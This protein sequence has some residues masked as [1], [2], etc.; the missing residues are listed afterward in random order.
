MNPRLSVAVAVRTAT[1]AFN[2]SPENGEEPLSFLVPPKDTLIFE[3]LAL[4]FAVP[5]AVKLTVLTP[6]TRR[7]EE[8]VRATACVFA[9]AAVR[10][11]AGEETSLSTAA[12]K[13]QSLYPIFVAPLY[14]WHLIVMYV[15]CA[16]LQ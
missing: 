3:R 9:S 16:F 1:A 2:I 14:V 5:L 7:S 8:P 15:Y 11:T 13:V 10:V 6:F 4:F 12:L